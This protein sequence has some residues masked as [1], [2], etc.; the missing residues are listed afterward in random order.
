MGAIGQVPRVRSELVRMLG[1]H[2]PASDDRL[3]RQRDRDRS[4]RSVR[5]VS[6]VFARWNLDLLDV[7]YRKLGGL[8]ARTSRWHVGR[9]TD[10]DEPWVRYLPDRVPQRH[11]GGV[12]GHRDR[13]E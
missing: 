9:F 8:V 10:D 1:Q 4:W 3:E 5:H 11:A 6:V 7:E 13:P 2:Q 12:L